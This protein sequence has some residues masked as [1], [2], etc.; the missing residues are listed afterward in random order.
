M[1]KAKDKFEVIKINVDVETGKEEVF[2]LRDEPYLVK[3]VY[4]DKPGQFKV[5][6]AFTEDTIEKK[7][8]INRG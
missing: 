7:E 1:G 6:A 5:G 8:E 3:A 2:L 4:P